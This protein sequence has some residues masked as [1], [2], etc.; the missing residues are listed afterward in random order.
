MKKLISNTKIYF[1]N[2]ITAAFSI[3]LILLAIIS[4]ACG[5]C[6]IYIHYT[7]LVLLALAVTVLYGGVVFVIRVI[8]AIIAIRELL[9]EDLNG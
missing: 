8:G 6:Q 4:L 3:P 2:W 1:G 9:K 7:Y 5:A